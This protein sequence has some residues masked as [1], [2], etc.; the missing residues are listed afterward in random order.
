MRKVLLQV[1]MLALALAFAFPASLLAVP[2]PII[3]SAQ[4]DLSAHKITVTGTNFGSTQP[5]VNLGATALTVTSFSP[6]LIRAALPSIGAGS[7]HLVVATNSSPPGI[8][9]LDVTIGVTGPVGPQGPVGPAGPQGSKGDAG[10]QG[11]PGIAGPVGP[12]GPAGPVGAV[13]PQGAPGPQGPPGDT[14]A[15]AA[16]V[17]ALQATVSSLQTQLRSAKQ[18]PGA[19]SLC[20]LQSRPGERGDWA[21][22]HFHGREH[23]HCQR[24]KQYRR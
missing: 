14:S 6:T 17:S 7:Y 23:S 21:E 24:L 20:H 8:A 16:Q 11:P 1:S 13:G 19:C 10:P 22:Y 12:Q 9:L 4:A 15:L 2:V 5:S 3:N 18:R